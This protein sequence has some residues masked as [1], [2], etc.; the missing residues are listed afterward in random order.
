MEKNDFI[1]YIDKN[2]VIWARGYS[3]QDTI[4]GYDLQEYNSLKA[5]RDLCFDKAEKYLSEL[6]GAGIRQKPI[7]PEQA[8]AEQA[9]I[10]LKMMTL[11]ET[12]QEEIK[13]LKSTDK[14]V[15]NEIL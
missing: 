10:N 3:Q 7:P 2:G 5:D 1:A 12:M 14:A 4:V 11:L 8:A 9:K 6:Y 15:I 13:S